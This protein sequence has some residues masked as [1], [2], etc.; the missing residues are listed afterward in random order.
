VYTA[1]VSGSIIK[2]AEGITD[3]Y[4]I[5]VVDFFDKGKLVD[6]KTSTLNVEDLKVSEDRKFQVKTNKKFTSYRYYLIKK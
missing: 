4:V 1:N 3:P 6:T 2:G 5:I